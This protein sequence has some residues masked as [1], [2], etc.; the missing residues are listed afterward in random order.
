MELRVSDFSSAMRI[1]HVRSQPDCL[2]N[3]CHIINLLLFLIYLT[4]IGEIEI[5]KNGNPMRD[6][7]AVRDR[8]REV[9]TQTYCLKWGWFVERVNF[10]LLKMFIHQ[11]KYSL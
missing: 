5:I 10:D 3:V 4:L 6:P 9:K 11:I 2:Y 1:F 7:E 8:I